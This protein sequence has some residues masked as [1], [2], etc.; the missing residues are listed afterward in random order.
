MVDLLVSLLILA[1]LLSVLAPALVH[2]REAARLATCNDN[3]RQIGQASMA[4]AAAND[5]FLPNNQISPFGS[6][7]TQILS[8]LGYQKVCDDYSDSADWWDSKKSQNRTIG[9]QR[10]TEF[11]CPDAPNG[12]RWIALQDEASQNFEMAPSDYVGSAGAYLH[13]N[14]VEKLHRGAMAYPG[15]HYGAS[16]QPGRRAVRLREI[17]DGR[18]NTLLVVE[19]ADRPNAWRMGKLVDDNSKPAMP[20]LLNPGISSGNWSAP[21]WN[22]VRSHDPKTGAAFGACAVN[23]S[24]EAGIYGFH[25][26]GANVAFADG[27]VR[28]LRAGLPQEIMV[29]LVSIADGEIIGE[30]DYLPK[31]NA[32]K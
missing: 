6:W 18:A 4:F 12:E 16:Q 2:S 17:L 9:Q 11:I 23:C 24:N 27:S 31:Q 25:T 20:K 26:A 19:I 21:N 1:V 28:T 5:G 30:V 22:H 7:N 13:T 3:L 29:A 10:V 32:A 15:R 14:T 8:Q